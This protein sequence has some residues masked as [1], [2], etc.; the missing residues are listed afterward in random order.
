MIKLVDIL[1]NEDQY[2]YDRKE[3]IK[4]TFHTYSCYYLVKFK[5]SINRTEAVERIR[6][7]KSVTIVDLR[8]DEKLN[9]INRSLADFEYSTVELKFV[10]NEEPSKQVE[11]IRK[12]MVGSDKAKG[13]DFIPGIV[14]A[15]AKEDTLIKLD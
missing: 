12:A 3:T 4:H 10:T 2:D 8:G 5:K 7:I 13:I 14:A 11:Y 9:K 15:K 6:G 1:M